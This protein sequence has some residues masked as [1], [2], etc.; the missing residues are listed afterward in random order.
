MMTL[1]LLK[2]IAQLFFM[3]ALGWL[4]V[5]TGR[6]KAEESRVLAVICLYAITPCMILSAFSIDRSP[7]V[8]GQ[9]GISLAAALGIHLGLFLLLELL[10]GPLK[11]DRIE[12]ASIFYSNAGNL[13]IPLVS[14]MLG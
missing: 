14:G 12:Q 5:K 3:A 9:M 1:V 6:L 2:Q 13:I 4:V 11:L 8:L 7:D 10:K